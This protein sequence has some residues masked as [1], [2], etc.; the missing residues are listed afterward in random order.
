MNRRDAPLPRRALARI[1]W[2]WLWDSPLLWSVWAC[3]G[4][5]LG[6]LGRVGRALGGA[7]EVRIRAE[8]ILAETVA[9][10]AVVRLAQGGAI[11]PGRKD[12]LSIGGLPVEVAWLDDRFE[13]AVE[14]G[15]ARHRFCGP[16]QPG[17][18]PAALGRSLTVS[19]TATLPPGLAAVREPLPLPPPAR[20]TGAAVHPALQRDSGIALLRLLA[21]TERDDYRLGEKGSR[22][23][24]LAGVDGG[25]I[26]VPGH[27]WVDSGA[28]ELTLDLDSDLTIVVAGNVYLGRTV[29]VRGARL[30]LVALPVG[31]Q[32]FCDVDGDGRCSGQEGRRH[33]GA[34]ATLEGAGNAWFGLPGLPTEH[35]ELEAAVFV[36]GY[37]HLAA[38]HT[39]VHGSLVCAGGAMLL[40]PA[41]EALTA[42]GSLLLDVERENAP[43]FSVSGSLR[44]GRVRP[45]LPHD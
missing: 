1:P 32:A 44:P 10:E 40:G 21:G 25:V 4:L 31:G 22:A 17:S 7:E 23:V 8:A 34:A 19:P 6:A 28:E 30:F 38:G 14:T 41:R 39:S 9:D 11:R 3:V 5:G 42:T 26:H 37:L 15:A 45:A 24:R 18:A 20:D 43:G 33:A 29:R 2:R 12:R 13:V 35:I 16:L 36:G 27:L